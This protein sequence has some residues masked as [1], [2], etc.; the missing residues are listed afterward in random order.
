M[1]E[2]I[3]DLNYIFNEMPLYSEE[4]CNIFKFKDGVSYKVDK[5]EVLTVIDDSVTDDWDDLCNKCSSL[6]K[7]SGMTD[8]EI[9][10][11]AKKCKEG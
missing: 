3:K 10:K 2:Q 7:E 6:I 4:I 9:D 5:K 8:K 11:I 1:E